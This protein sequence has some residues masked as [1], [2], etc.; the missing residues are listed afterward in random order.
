MSDSP[1][2]PSFRAA[3]TA[4]YKH[5]RA[6]RAADEN[7]SAAR[8]AKAPP[9]QAEK[10]AKD[11]RRSASADDAKRGAE[12]KKSKALRDRDVNPQKPAPAV[13][14]KMQSKTASRT[15]EVF[16]DDAAAKPARASKPVPATI[17]PYSLPASVV[18]SDPAA[19]PLSDADDDRINYSAFAAGLA[20]FAKLAAGSRE[21]SFAVDDT[22]SDS[23]SSLG[24]GEVTVDSFISGIGKPWSSSD[25]DE[26]AAS[27]S[28]IAKARDSLTLRRRKGKSAVKPEPFVPSVMGVKTPHPRRDDDEDELVAAIADFAAIGGKE[29]GRVRPGAKIKVEKEKKRQGEDMEMESDDWLL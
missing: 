24:E 16:H 10:G 28:L 14:K 6:Q 5:R 19:H 29:T 23:G 12:E 13:P 3:Q 8:G 1:L 2:P 27:T 11:R 4:T 18:D 25:E 20:R 15:F 21:P 22:G 9:A 26:A 7:H 17:D